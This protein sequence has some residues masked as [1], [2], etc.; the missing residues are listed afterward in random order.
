MYKRQLNLISRTTNMKKQKATKQ[1]ITTIK[2]LWVNTLF[3]PSDYLKPG[4]LLKTSTEAEFLIS[5]GR[6]FQYL[7]TTKRKEHYAAENRH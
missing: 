2:K 1:L 5:L 3:P 7:D 4:H 6:L